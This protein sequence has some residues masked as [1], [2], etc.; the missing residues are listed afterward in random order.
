MSRKQT[1]MNFSQ[2]ALIYDNTRVIPDNIINKAIMT[3]E[4]NH[5]ITKKARLLDIGCGTGQ[6]TKCFAENGYICTGIDISGEML[7]IAREKNIAHTEFLIGDARNIPFKDNSFEICISSKLFLHIENWQ[8]AIGEIIRIIPEGGCFLYINE[9]GYF[10]NNVRKYFR[11]SADKKGFKNRF[12]GEYDLDK[13]ANFFIASGLYH[14][15]YQGHEFSWKKVLSY[16][17]AFTDIKNRAFAEFWKI[18]EKIYNDMLDETSCWIKKQDKSWDTV[19]I[20][21]PGLKLD[22]YLK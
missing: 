18:P 8:D 12:L 16:K 22:V 1:V 14:K 9:I 5:H 21:N 15:R 20:M 2:A 19:Q 10:S 13:I 11:E 3:L 6:L 4:K 7:C 17:E